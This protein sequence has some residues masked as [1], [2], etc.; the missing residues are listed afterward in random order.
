MMLKSESRIFVVEMLVK[1]KPT[2]NGDS[3]NP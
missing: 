1:V 2:A 3:C